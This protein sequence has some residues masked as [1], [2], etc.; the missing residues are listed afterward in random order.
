MARKEINI[1]GTSFLD[2]LSGALGAVI[3]LF[4]IVPKMTQTDMELLDRVKQVELLAGEVEE[5][6]DRLENSIPKD[7]MQ[8]IEFELS[9]LRSKIQELQNRVSELTLDVKR[10][11]DENIE[12]KE[13]VAQQQELIAELQ[14]RLEEAEL[15][16][17]ES[18][19]RARVAEREL[20]HSQESRTV[21][22]VEQ[23]LGV[24]SKFGIL[25]R[26]K[27]T[28][29]DVDL[30]VQ[31]F[32]S[33]PEHCWRMYPSKK[34]GILGEDVRERG[35][36]EAERFELFYVPEIYPET[37]TAWVDI[38]N[39]SSGTRAVIDAT[40]IFHPGKPDEQRYSVPQFELSGSSSHCFVTFRLSDSG[41]EVL[42][43]REPIW[44]E[45]VV[46]K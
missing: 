25:C 38:Y 1:F 45:G 37:Y 18:E 5:L 2:L 42:P 11:N 26:W 29:V 35:F 39:G 15:R 33:D 14:Q 10:L 22:S 21:N 28:D 32:G 43:H 40:L 44:G 16:A 20:E 8:E 7:L 27:Q 6:V 19:N 46:V 36:D 4:I 24:F 12:L 31:R 41:F 13:Q 34:W 17:K 23:V 30:G 3:I 9:E